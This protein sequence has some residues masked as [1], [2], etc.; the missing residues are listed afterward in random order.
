MKVL[1]KTIENFITTGGV[2]IFPVIESFFLNFM[3][4]S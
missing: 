4:S 1:G 3:I 2:E